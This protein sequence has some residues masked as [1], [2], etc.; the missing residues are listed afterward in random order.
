M[1]K[2]YPKNTNQDGI[3]SITVTVIF[4]MVISLTVLGFS[5]VTRRNSQEALDKQLSSQAFYA[6]EV[7]V[8]D[9]RTKIASLV[10]SN[11]EVPEQ[12][13]CKDEGK[14]T[15]NGGIVDEENGVSYSCIIVKTDLDNLHY[16][17]IGG[18]SIV[19]SLNTSTGGAIGA[20]VLSW[21]APTNDNNRKVSDCPKPN[22]FANNPWTK[23][24]SA[25]QW[26]SKCPFG[27][28]RIDVTPINTD[29]MRNI[30]T[31]LNRTMSF[32]AYPASGDPSN[33]SAIRAVGYEKSPGVVNQ[34]IV[35]PAT[36]N[37]QECKL[38]LEGLNFATASMRV[39]S[40]YVGAGS[41][42][43][44]AP[45]ADPAMVG[46][47]A[48]S[49]YTFDS[50]VEIDVTGKAQDVLRRISVRVSKTGGGTRT[51]SAG[52]SDYA[53]H[54]EESICKRFVASHVLGRVDSAVTG[55]CR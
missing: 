18:S 15:K 24:E 38:K 6:A 1:R 31:A 9:V 14:Y 49:A 10:E 32:F 30:D 47:G 41:F 4:I 19:A 44:H 50:Q 27:V 46:E 8:N 12:T 3:V 43:I 48:S 51:D 11:G 23:F 29:V 25:N 42:T 52:F 28:M 54:T 45:E 33:P 21:R 39:R 36:C 34:G 40:V 17:E 16:S 2:I 22:S 7:G 13:E 37:D 53:L 55:Q 5:Q 26:S 20:P 35:V